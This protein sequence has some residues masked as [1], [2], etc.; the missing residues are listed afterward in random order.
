MWQT[1]IHPCLYRIYLGVGWLNGV[2]VVP[3]YVPNAPSLV[4]SVIP[5]FISF[6]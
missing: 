4:F 5:I 6:V 1:A 2:F 3:S